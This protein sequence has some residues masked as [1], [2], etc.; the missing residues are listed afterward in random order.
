MTKLVLGTVQLSDERDGQSVV[1][2]TTLWHRDFYN[3][4]ALQVSPS[5]SALCWPYSVHQLLPDIA[6]AAAAGSTSCAPGA[7]PGANYQAAAASHAAAALCICGGFCWQLWD[8]CCCVCG[9][10]RSVPCSRCGEVLH[11][12]V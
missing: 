2:A 10:D 3:N 4:A 9:V 12:I 8:Q 1:A 7:A 11:G 6:T 5:V